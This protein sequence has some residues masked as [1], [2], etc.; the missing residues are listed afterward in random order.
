MDSSL[1][2]PP[3]LPNFRSLNFKSF[4]CILNSCA[5][6]LLSPFSPRMEEKPKPNLLDPAVESSLQTSSGLPL[7]P[8]IP[9]AFHKLLFSQV[10][11]S[12]SDAIIIVKGSFS[13]TILIKSRVKRPPRSVT[14]ELS[15]I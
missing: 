4:I 13:I 10:T 14:V 2:E 6:L 9:L 8:R 12:L 15:G 3:V 7:T 11:V 1:S 5:D